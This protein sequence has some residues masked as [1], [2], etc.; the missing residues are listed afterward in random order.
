LFLPSRGCAQISMNLTR[1][2]R[3]SLPAVFRWVQR[4]AAEKGVAVQESEIIGVI[5]QATLDHEPPEAILWHTYRPTQVLE[6]WLPA[7]GTR[8]QK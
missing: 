5:P 1:P 3:T 4:A 2:E 7:V 8:S 6:H